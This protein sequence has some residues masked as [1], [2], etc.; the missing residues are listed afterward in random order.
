LV[1]PEIFLPESASRRPCT[2]VDGR[3]RRY[4]LSS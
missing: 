1:Y 4:I 2:A 3:K